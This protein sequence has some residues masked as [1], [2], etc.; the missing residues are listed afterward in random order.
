M[1]ENQEETISAG[2]ESQEPK[3]WWQSRTVWTGI[4][5]V[6]TAAAG[7]SAGEMNAVDA[8]QLAVTSASAIFL[9]LGMAK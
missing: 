4:A 8:V 7:L 6:A 3:K 1:D 2:L 5:G 9:R